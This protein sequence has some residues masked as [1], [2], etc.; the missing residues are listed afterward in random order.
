VAAEL[1]LYALQ[2]EA[3]RPKQKKLDVEIAYYLFGV[4]SP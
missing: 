3:R 1:F 2:G 4:A